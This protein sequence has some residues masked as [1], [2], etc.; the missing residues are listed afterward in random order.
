MARTA[1]L[2]CVQYLTVE[3]VMICLGVG[4]SK[5]Y[6]VIRDLNDE[7]EKD[8]FITI[9]GKVPE[10]K[11]RERLYLRDNIRPIQATVIKSGPTKKRR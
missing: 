11:F 3:D 10:R 9:A 6:E 2:P 8:G 7:L 5:A 4:R 1:A